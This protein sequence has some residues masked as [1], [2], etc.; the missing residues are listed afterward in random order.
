V[1]SWKPKAVEKK[2][3]FG[4]NLE[5]HPRSMALKQKQNPVLL[6]LPESPNKSTALPFFVFSVGIYDS[7]LILAPFT[8][9]IFGDGDKMKAPNYRCI[10]WNTPETWLGQY[11]S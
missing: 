3:L 9:R 11:W 6:S 7:L 4:L 10:R 2:G 5:M 1:E 8:R